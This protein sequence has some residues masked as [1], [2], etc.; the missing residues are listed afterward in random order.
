MILKLFLTFLVSFFTILVLDYVWLWIIIK[1]FIMK[2]FWN[3]IEVKN[4]K[5]DLNILTW[6][7]AWAL[8]AFSV[9]VFIVTK[10]SNIKEV[11]LYSALLWFVVYGIYDLTNLSFIKG[12]PFK[13]SIVDVLWWS[14]AYTVVWIISFYFYNYISKIL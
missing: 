9:V 1:Q 14:F 3:L 2:E 13:F 7:M 6:L 11:I 5:I 8:I 10:Y 4:G 12:Y